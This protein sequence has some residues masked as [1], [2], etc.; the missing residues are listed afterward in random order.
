[1]KRGHSSR[2]SLKR[3]S[4]TMRWGCHR[5]SLAESHS[6][7]SVKRMSR[8]WGKAIT[9]R[10]RSAASSCSGQADEAPTP[11]AGLMTSLWVRPGRWARS[12]LQFRAGTTMDVEHDDITIADGKDDAVF[13][14]PLAVKELA[15]FFGEFAALGRTRTARGLAGQRLH[16]F[17][18]TL[19]PAFGL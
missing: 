6:T 3:R 2:S 11:F 15:Q 9:P 13:V 16:L 12:G 14:L 5:G 18:E 4:S 17:K 7:S 10:R 19:I 8:S 1:A